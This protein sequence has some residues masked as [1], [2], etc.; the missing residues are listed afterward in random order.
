M[1]AVPP[2]HMHDHDSFPYGGA[3]SER[4]TALSEDECWNLIAGGGVGRL[5]F[6]GRSGPMVLP[7]NY[8]FHEGGIVFRTLPGGTIDWE[9][10]TGLAGVEYTVAFEVDHHDES[11][12]TGWSVVVQ[13]S[14]HHPTPEEEARLAAEADVTPWPGEERLRYLRII[15]IRITGRRVGPA[16]ADIVKT[17][18]V[19]GRG[20][21]RVG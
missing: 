7:V 3:R 21:P 10:D 20:R 8:T 15:P 16:P 9:L 12:R 13:G 5:A 1:P 14:L 2:G 11:T 6:Q 18:A 19:P 17:T 4:L